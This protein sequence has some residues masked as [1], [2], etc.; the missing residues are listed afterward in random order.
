M[1]NTKKCR[2]Y[3]LTAHGT[4]RYG[5]WPY[6]AHLDHVAGLALTYGYPHLVEPAYLHD[7]LE[8]TDKVA[9]DLVEVFGPEMTNLVVALTKVPGDKEASYNKVLAAGPNAVALKILDRLANTTASARNNPE[10][11]ATYRADYAL[12]RSILYLKEHETLWTNLES[13]TL[14][15]AP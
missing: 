12:F 3:A 11:L 13:V 7:V 4:Q 2:E 6:V 15:G 8:D 9:A 5:D 1:E 14:V 10:M